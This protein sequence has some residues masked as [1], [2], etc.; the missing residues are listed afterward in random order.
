[1]QVAMYAR[2]RGVA[3]IESAIFLPL[4]LLL[5][6]G[7]IWSV[8]S[9][10]QN[11]RVQIAVRYS[12]LVSNESAPYVGYSTY[13][14][15]NA[16]RTP[17]VTTA[18]TAP[19]GD[20]LTNTNSFPG[21]TSPPFWSPA[22]TTSGTC[23][24]STAVLSGG[25]LTSNVL[26]LQTT[27]NISTQITVP[28]PL[29]GSLG[30]NTQT[31]TAS[32]NFFDTPDLSTL[33]ACYSELDAAVAA[34][35]ENQPQ[36]AITAATPVPS[37][38]PTNSLKERLL[39]SDLAPVQARAKGSPQY[40]TR[41][42]LTVGEGAV[43]GY[44]ALAA[45]DTRAGTASYAL[46]VVNQSGH[47]LWARMTC[48]SMHAQPILAYPLDVQIAAYSICETL[49]PVRISDVG[50]YDRAIVQI[51]GG[52]VA[53]SLEAPAPA[54]SR[55]RSHGVAIALAALAVT[56]AAGLGAAAATP[57]INVLAAPA[58]MFPQ[59]TLDV[60]YAYGGWAAMQYALK[61]RDGRQ[62][63]RGLSGTARGHAAL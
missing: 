17:A 6:Y 56:L 9:S 50:P 53:F 51:A 33:M 8:Q 1:M 11:E 55:V 14:L 3:M 34:S 16:V 42:H 19:S 37:I 40:G 2:M 61:T 23:T 39:M 18:C 57:R 36:G 45:S 7:V 63:V 41:A 38:L 29:Q 13:A 47:A 48:A 52:D 15:Y 28:G 12:G 49:L 54:T 10:V 43:E 20:A 44:L 31:L 4:F 24:K 46:R 59:S 5:L 62:T 25:Q 58:R 30:S 27:S 21:P 35:L 26:F 22:G 60:P 32:Q